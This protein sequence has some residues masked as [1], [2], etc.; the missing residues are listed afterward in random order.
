VGTP[1]GDS[2][3]DYGIRGF[4]MW[5]MM[6]GVYYKKSPGSISLRGYPP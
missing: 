4:L 1:P 3:R 5:E 2:E 6:W